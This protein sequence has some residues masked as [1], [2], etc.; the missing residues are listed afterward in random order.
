MRV[1]KMLNLLVGAA[2]VAIE[3]LLHPTGRRF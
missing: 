3:S 1:R 2:Y